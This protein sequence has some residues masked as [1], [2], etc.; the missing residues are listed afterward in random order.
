MLTTYDF[1]ASWIGPL[2]QAVIL[3]SESKVAQILEAGISTWNEPFLSEAT[4]IRARDLAAMW[5]PEIVSV[6]IRQTFD[7]ETR[8]DLFR[9]SSSPPSQYPLVELAFNIGWK[10]GRTH[11]K[12][13]EDAYQDLIQLALDTDYPI[14]FD[15][16]ERLDDDAIAPVIINHLANRRQ[17]LREHAIR[18]LS[19]AESD[20]LELFDARLIDERHVEVNQALERRGID[21]PNALTSYRRPWSEGRSVYRNAWHSATLSE[22]LGNAGFDPERFIRIEGSSR[23]FF[24]ACLQE[25]ALWRHDIFFWLS[26]VVVGSESSFKSNGIHLNLAPHRD[27]G[28]N[29]WDDTPGV[30]Q[31]TS[32][33]D[34]VLWCRLSF[35]HALMALL[36]HSIHRWDRRMHMSPDFTLGPNGVL[37]I[38]RESLLI[39]N[40][41]NCICACSVAGCTPLHTFLKVLIFDLT[42]EWSFSH[43]RDVH[44]DLLRSAE[45]LQALLERLQA[46][47][48]ITMQFLRLYAFTSLG[49][50]HTCCATAMEHLPGRLRRVYPSRSARFAPWTNLNDPKAMR[51]EDSDTSEDPETLESLEEVMDQLGDRNEQHKGMELVAFV[52]TEFIPVLERALAERQ[53][54]RLGQED[55]REVEELVVKWKPPLVGPSPIHEEKPIDGVETEVIPPASLM[56][57]KTDEERLRAIKQHV[58]NVCK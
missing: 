54:V 42:G 9:L 36:G 15:M 38:L 21:V 32:E 52:E 14:A 58:D 20:A 55:A 49:Y 37:T 16:L 12:A 4:D 53:A 47:R 17:R 44:D 31:C 26:K 48:S 35:V 30:S 18:Y 3:R 51:E 29:D 2:C 11:G 56:V 27:C 19:K 33:K 10:H 23:H 24:H 39:S 13:S 7:S 34:H 5:F 50:Q 25:T 41:D 45:I 1:L 57:L 8:L 40:E 28:G 43:V 46:P 6:T 22:A